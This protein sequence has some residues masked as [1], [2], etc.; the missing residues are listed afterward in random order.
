MADQGIVQAFAHHAFLRGLSHRHLLILASGVRPV[1]F[2]PN[3]YLAREG[4]TAR[5]F[6]L[7]QSGHVAIQ[8][9]RPDRPP[10]RVQTVGPGDVVGWSWIVPPYRWQFDCQAVETVQGLVFDAH[11]LRD[12]CEQDYQL[13]HSLLQHLVA[14]ISG[15][16]AGT[17]RQ[18][19]GLPK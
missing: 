17:R 18:L 4:E 3:E 9:R 13:G 2:S 16:L 7:I 6:Y 11:W 1:T 5:A 15:R 8:T 14:V 10:V 19:L 12:Q